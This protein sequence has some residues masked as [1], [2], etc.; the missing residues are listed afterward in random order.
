MTAAA[1]LLAALA[2][3]S[4]TELISGII[5]ARLFIGVRYSRSFEPKTGAVR[6]R[7]AGSG[8]VE[9]P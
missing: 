5:S 9:A 6:T 1:S 2:A 8:V 4:W 3:G 7:A